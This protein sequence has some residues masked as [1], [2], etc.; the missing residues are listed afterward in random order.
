LRKLGLACKSNVC[1]CTTELRIPV[2]RWESHHRR[3]TDRPRLRGLEQGGA[4]V[5]AALGIGIIGT[6]LVV[7]LVIVAILFFVRRR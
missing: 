3:I 5:V 7:I 6:I 1:Q 2:R 4:I